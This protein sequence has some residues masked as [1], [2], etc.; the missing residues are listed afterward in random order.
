VS[1]VSD[2]YSRVAAGFAA[3]LERCSPGMLD[4]PSPCEG[5]TGRD[6]A[7]HVVLVHRRV[8]ASLEGSDAPKPAPGE[9]LVVAI[10]DASTAVNAALSEPEQAAK[11]VSGIFGEQ[12]FELLVGRRL[13]ADTLIHTWDLARAT[14]Q[15]DHL[16]AEAATKALEFLTPIDEA[17]RRPGGFGPKLA[18]PPG[19]D[20]QAKLL[21]FAGRGA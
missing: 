6:V 1:E 19:A 13:C 2:R 8:L 16:D 18:P 7:S 15:D 17:I 9:D 20:A 11:P 14:G 21:A 10:H 5:W 12:S 4:G 3:S